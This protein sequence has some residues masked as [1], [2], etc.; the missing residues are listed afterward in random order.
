MAETCPKVTMQPMRDAES[1]SDI[2]YCFGGGVR[3]FVGDAG[4]FG[5]EIEGFFVIV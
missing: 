4:V 5:F 2:L 1:N 3:T